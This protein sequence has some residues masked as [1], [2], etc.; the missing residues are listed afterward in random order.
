MAKYPTPLI[1]IEKISIVNLFLEFNIYP[2]SKNISYSFCLK[3]VKVQ[4]K[5][6]TV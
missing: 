6:G 5:S 3:N 4:H 2:R 1:I